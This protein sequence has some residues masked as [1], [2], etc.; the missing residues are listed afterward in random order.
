MNNIAKGQESQLREQMLETARNLNDLG[1]NRGTSGNLSVR[2]TESQWLVT[3][4][5]INA[6]RLSTQSMVLMSFEGRVIG[7]GRP[8]SEWRFHQDI[9][10][11]RPEVNAVIHTHSTFA[12]AMS[13]VQKD[14]P[15]FHYMIAAA[16]GDS[17]RCAPYALFGTQ[18]LSEY[19]V[20]ALV[21]RKACLL[22]NHG[23]IAV[24][25]NLDAALALAVE[26]ESLCEQYSTA[27]R[28]GEPQ[29]LTTAQMHAVLEQFK[30][31]GASNQ[32]S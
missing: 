18:E 16:G 5:G 17:I 9:L 4:S 8:S 6:V 22:S 7:P 24:G 11:T 19:A 21:G 30:T 14:V 3:P 31:Y 28:L 10:A 27:M 25:K 2:L 15:A 12:T 29:L 26:V 20:S 23:M 32:D 1:L 13:C